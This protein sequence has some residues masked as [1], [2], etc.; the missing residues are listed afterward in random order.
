MDVISNM[1]YTPMLVEQMAEEGHA[2]PIMLCEY[3]HAMGN[4]V[5]KYGGDFEGELTNDG[6]KFARDC[7]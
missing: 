1:Y 2:L 3:A 4:G 7:F 5:Q 6:N